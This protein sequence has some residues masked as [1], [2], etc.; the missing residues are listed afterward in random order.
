MRFDQALRGLEVGAPVEFI[1]V[2]IGSVTAVDLDYNAQKRSFP[3]LVTAVLYPHRMGRAYDT[4]REQG[5]AQSED[6]MAQLVGQLVAKGLRVQ[7]RRVSLLTGQLY[8]A[9]DFI[10]DSGRTTFNEKLRP[11]EI[12]TARGS[13][14][15]LQYRVASI[16]KKIDELPLGALVH[17]LDEDLT[18]IGVTVAHLDGGVLPPAAIA[19]QDL[20]GT[21]NEAQ[22]VLSIDSPLQQEL[23]ATL[24]ESRNTL[25]EIRSLADLFNRHPESLIRGKPPEK[26]P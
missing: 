11:L 22:A 2:N 10:P 15:D 5:T 26:T 24:E 19:L 23:K 4:L 6:K 25:R 14:D 3:V 13:I 20:H 8:L 16:A 18:S 1:G 21:L 17:H 9:M 7:A 12:P